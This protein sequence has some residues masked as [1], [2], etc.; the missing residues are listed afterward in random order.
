MVCFILIPY[1]N[2][3]RC[4]VLSMTEQRLQ[5]SLNYQYFMKISI[6]RV[7]VQTNNSNLISSDQIIV[8][9]WRHPLTRSASIQTKET[10]RLLNYY[11][12]LG[13]AMLMLL[14]IKKM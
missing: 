12:I 9:I 3:L 11:S 14:R 6:V 5:E 7:R 4:S 10:A 13:L 8:A 2:L 1:F